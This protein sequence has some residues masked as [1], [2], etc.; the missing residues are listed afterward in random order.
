MLYVYLNAVNSQLDL[1][2]FWQKYMAEM[3]QQRLQDDKVERHDL[4]SSLLAAN[5]EAEDGSTLTDN[6]VMGK[7]LYPS[8]SFYTQAITANI[9]VFLLAGHEVC[10]FA[11]PSC[12]H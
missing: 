11:S 5:S 6:E 12:V 4:F 3:I 8:H 7:E 10:L 1:R 9:F 2:I